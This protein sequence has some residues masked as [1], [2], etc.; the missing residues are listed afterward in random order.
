MEENETLSSVERQNQILELVE[1]QRRVTVAAICEQFSV[2]EATARRDLDVLAVQGKVQRFHGGAIHVRQA[3]PEIPV[4]QRNIEQAQEKRLI[5]KEAAQLVKDGETIFMG[6]GTTVLE[7]AR[8][9]KHLTRLTV[10][11]NSLLVVNTLVDRP[12]VTV[13]ALGGLLRRSEFSFIGHITEQS[14]SEV[15]ADKVFLGIRALSLE[16]GLTNDY[17]PETM[18]DRA[19][20]SIG[21]EI[22]LVA[23]HTKIGR[24]STAFVAPLTGIHILVTDSLTPPEF[25]TALTTHGIRVIT[26]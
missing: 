19:I 11:T 5:G 7:V 18:T 15:R 10:I 2:S 20:L 16:Q 17:L 9:L 8:N 6:S 1:R 13:I 3:P 14:L 23:D 12:M 24:L 25:I 26:C 22:V 21:R 4:L